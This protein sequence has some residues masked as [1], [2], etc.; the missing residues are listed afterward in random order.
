MARTDEELATDKIAAGLLLYPL[1]W[2]G[3]AWLVG[4]L[5]GHAW[6]FLLLLLPS[7]FFAVGWRERLEGA[8]RSA[9]GLFAF[10]LRGDRRLRTER[11]TLAR[12]IGELG[13]ALGTA[14]KAL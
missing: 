9:R 14:E 4:H 5:W 12:E 2:G 8:R 3:E 11:E 10:L 13:A 1:C 7:G 6:L